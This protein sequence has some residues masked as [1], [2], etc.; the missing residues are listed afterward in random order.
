MNTYALLDARISGYF[1]GGRG[2][3]IFRRSRRVGGDR[4]NAIFH[5]PG[6]IRC[7]SDCGARR[8]MSLQGGLLSPTKMESAI[9]VAGPR[10]D[11]NDSK[12]RLCSSFLP[13]GGK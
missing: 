7:S 9:G 2:S 4:E 6:A 3:G 5:L 13:W 11:S 8:C 1:S 10:P 12:R